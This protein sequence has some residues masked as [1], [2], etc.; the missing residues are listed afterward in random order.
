M[1][2]NINQ[3]RTRFDV[4]ARALRFYEQVELLSPERDA[5]RRRFYDA[6]Q[7]ARMAAICEGKA[8]G[9]SIEQIRVA[10]GNGTTLTV[11]EG[12]LQ[13]L[14]DR[15]LEEIDDLLVRLK[16]IE[17]LSG[18]CDQRADRLAR[19]LLPDEDLDEVRARA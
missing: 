17:R 3:M 8:L 19:A 9:M 16:N 15:T 13:D 7:I 11:P 10:L 18:T 12:D 14:H 5:A 6:R 4:T 2:L 1:K